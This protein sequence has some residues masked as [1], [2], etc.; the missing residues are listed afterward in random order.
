MTGNKKAKAAKVARTGCLGKRG[1]EIS[2]WS[3]PLNQQAKKPPK[4]AKSYLT[5]SPSKRNQPDRTI[6]RFLSL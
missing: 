4:P 5:S 1:Y 6:P 2:R 3:G